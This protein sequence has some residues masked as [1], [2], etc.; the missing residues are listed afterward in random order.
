MQK[1]PY[2]DAD[3]PDGTLRA[4]PRAKLQGRR[5]DIA[6]IPQG[7]RRRAI[8]TRSSSSWQTLLRRVFEKQGQDKS[9]LRGI[10]KRGALARLESMKVTDLSHG[11][12]GGSADLSW[13][14]S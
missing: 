4:A 2:L 10:A 3:A 13:V 8:S 5:A 6:C 7:A 9:A 12:L 14:G 11:K 1:G